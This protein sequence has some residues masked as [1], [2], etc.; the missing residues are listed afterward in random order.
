MILRPVES[1][2][3][4]ILWDAFEAGLSRSMA[5][6]APSTILPMVGCLAEAPRWGQRA[7]SEELAQDARCRARRPKKWRVSFWLGGAQPR[8][9]RFRDPEDVGGQV[10]V[11]DLG[12]RKTLTVSTEP[13]KLLMALLS[14]GSTEFSPEFPPRI[15]LPNFPVQIVSGQAA[16]AA[17]ELPADDASAL[18][19]KRTPWGRM[20]RLCRCFLWNWPKRWCGPGSHLRQ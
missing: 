13:L 10:F 16:R 8:P 4:V 15:F 11:A 3:G 5:S 2:A 9:L 12:A 6:M 19:R 18:P 17:N 7:S 20:R 1:G 14:G